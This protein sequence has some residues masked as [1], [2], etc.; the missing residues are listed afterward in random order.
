MYGSLEKLYPVVYGS[1]KMVIMYGSLYEISC[2]IWVPPKSNNIWVPSLIYHVVLR[3][4]SREHQTFFGPSIFFLLLERLIEVLGHMKITFL[5]IFYSQNFLLH[6][7]KVEGSD[8][9]WSIF[10]KHIFWVISFNFQL[11]ASIKKPFYSSLEGASFSCWHL[12][13]NIY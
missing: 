8:T 13:S 10:E 11:T 3:T 7:F 5:L 1:P 6:P 4:A 12:P 9:F 2:S